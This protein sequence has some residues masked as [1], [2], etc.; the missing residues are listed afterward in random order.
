MPDFEV[1]SREWEKQTGYDSIDT[2]RRVYDR[3]PSGAYICVWPE[4]TFAR[5]DAAELWRHVH[6][7]HGP[8]C[9]PPDQQ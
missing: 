2:I 7:A 3:S 6:T 4:C 9:L 8:N 1:I 5:K